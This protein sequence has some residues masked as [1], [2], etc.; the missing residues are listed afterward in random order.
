MTIQTNKGEYKMKLKNL[1]LLVLVLALILASCTTQPTATL[2]ATEAVVAET[3]TS[4]PAEPV[5]LNVFA[6]ASLTEPFG[7]IGKVFEANHPGV[8][9]GFRRLSAACP[10]DQRGRSGGC[11][12]Q[13]QQDTDG[14]SY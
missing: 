7:E 2:T 1:F 4:A 11:I 10:T 5:D 13:R 9:A 12:H 8:T 14:C 3:P 6:A